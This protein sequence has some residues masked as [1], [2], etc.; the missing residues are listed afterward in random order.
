[1][2]KATQ[3]LL[4][5][6]P[7]SKIYCYRCN[8]RL[9]EMTKTPPSLIVMNPYLIIMKWRLVHCGDEKEEVF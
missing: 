4:K 7:L 2:L 3:G 5:K 1:M 6:P 9:T 8:I